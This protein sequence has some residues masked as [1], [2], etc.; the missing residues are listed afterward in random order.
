M[1]LGVACGAWWQGG[2][3]GGAGVFAGDAEIR[4]A[5]DAIGGDFDGGL[6]AG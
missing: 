1:A 2:G 5:I 3:G 4:G 6:P